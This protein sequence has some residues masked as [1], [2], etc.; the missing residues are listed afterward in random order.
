MNQNQPTQ[1]PPQPKKL[2]QAASNAQDVLAQAKAIFPFDLFPDTIIVD[3]EKVTVNHREFFQVGEEISTQIHD[4]LNVEADTGP[5]LGSLKLWTRYFSQEPLQVRYLPRDD[6]QKLK[7][8][9]QGYIIAMK[10]DIDC[11]KFSLKEL[12]PLLQQMGRSPE[13]I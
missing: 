2:E 10:K 6:T 9:L 5:F 1:N 13:T 4:V 3:R 7:E 8:I 11:S 12:V